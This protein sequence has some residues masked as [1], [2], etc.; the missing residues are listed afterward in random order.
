MLFACLGWVGVICGMVAFA[1]GAFAYVTSKADGERVQA[2]LTCILGVTSVLVGFL[3][4]G[5]AQIM[6]AVVDTA[7]N[8]GEML[9]MMK[10][11]LRPTLPDQKTV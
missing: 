2:G 5:M 10:S 7:D 11:G 8:T 1:I 9:A 3:Q 6:R 4:V